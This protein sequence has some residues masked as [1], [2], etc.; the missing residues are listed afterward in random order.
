[1]ISSQKSA[2]LLDISEKAFL[3]IFKMRRIAVNAEDIKSEDDWIYDT[4]ILGLIIER[5]KKV[6]EEIKNGDF[7]TLEDLQS[8]LGIE[9]I[10]KL[11]IPVY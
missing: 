2:E 11:K 8:E 1:L 5:E 10:E 3:K 9:G 4:E 6:I 7:T